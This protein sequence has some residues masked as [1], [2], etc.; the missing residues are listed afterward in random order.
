MLRESL[1]NYEPVVFSGNVGLLFLEALSPA[2]AVGLLRQRKAA[3]EEMLQQAHSH[4]IHEG[5]PALLLVHQI[6]HLATERQWLAE[7]IA[8]LESSAQG[9]DHAG[10]HSPLG[11]GH[12]ETEG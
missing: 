1:E 8:Q 11:Q 3:V 9:D 10:G 7:V 4:E 12:G 2:E 5:S 6:R